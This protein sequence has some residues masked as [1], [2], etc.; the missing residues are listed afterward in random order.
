MV[1]FASLLPTT[2]SHSL[3]ISQ[4][5]KLT[6]Q[7]GC[8]FSQPAGPNSP[9]PG[10]APDAS[11]RSPNPTQP[12]NNQSG[13]QSSSSRR[14]RRDP[15]PLDQH[16]NRP[17]R[18]HIWTSERRRW[19]RRQL[20]RER[21]EFFDTRVT[22]R[23][24]IWQTIHATLQVLW[25]P[26]SDDS[27]DEG[28]GGLATAQSIIDAA[29]ISLPTGNLVNGAYDPL[30]NLYPLPEWV[31]SDPQ[32]LM[33]DDGD[34]K[35]TVEDPIIEDDGAVLADA[36]RRREEKGKAAVD[37]K[38]QVTLRARLSENG[39]DIQV[40]VNKSDSVRKVIRK[41]SEAAAV[42]KKSHLQQAPSHIIILICPNAARP[43][44][45]DSSGIHGQNPKGERFPR[46][47][48][49]AEWPYC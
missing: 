2:C 13:Y 10:G 24:E 16:I 49:M 44:K 20:D 7:Q 18:R 25:D 23:S 19:T 31:V 46:V 3:A 4:N 35:G 30:G 34:A 5:Q 22:G 17:L 8:C 48:R 9:Y 36:E 39:R 33:E 43:N 47:A 6:S 21:A 14:R 42:S 26:A 15:G 37:A 11:T 32:N 27:Q 40:L 29:E 38:T 12:E 1:C 28:E 41:I 45:E